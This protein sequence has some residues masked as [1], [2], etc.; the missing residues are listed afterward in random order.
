MTKFRGLVASCLIG[1]LGT[2]AGEAFAIPY[3][4]SCPSGAR[5]AGGWPL[6]FAINGNC[7]KSVGTGSLAGEVATALKAKG[8]CTATIAHGDIRYASDIDSIVKTRMIPLITKNLAYVNP[9]KIGAAGFSAGGTVATYL[10]T[11]WAKG[12]D[13]VT[14]TNYNFHVGAVVNYYGPLRFDRSPATD[15]T[16][17]LTGGGGLF[18][19]HESREADIDVDI[20]GIRQGSNPDCYCSSRGTTQCVCDAASRKYMDAYLTAYSPSASSRVCSFYSDEANLVNMSV[21]AYIQNK[22]PTHV[23]AL[24]LCQGWKDSNVDADQNIHQ[25]ESWWRPENSVVVETDDGHGFPYSV[26]ESA[27]TAA[28]VMKP[29]DW[30]VSRLANTSSLSPVYR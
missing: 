1:A 6:V 22:Q 15:A 25:A 11:E 10:G 27:A 5:P 16:G 18:Y 21:A 3:G 26:C 12:V 13:P 24:Y 14:G 23:A 19:L 2:L 7:F 8:V 28:G 17:A 30:L 4:I 29:T 20:P 9:Q